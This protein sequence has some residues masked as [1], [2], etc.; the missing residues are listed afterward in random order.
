MMATLPPQANVSITRLRKYLKEDEL[1]PDSIN[2]RDDPAL[3]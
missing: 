2:R 1:D 3:G